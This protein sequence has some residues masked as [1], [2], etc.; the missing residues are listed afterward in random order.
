MDYESVRSHGRAIADAV[1]ASDRFRL[2]YRPHPLT[3]TVDS[4]V[5][6]AD[7]AIRSAVH[8]AAQRDPAAGHRVDT[9]TDFAHLLADV[10]LR[11]EMQAVLG[12][13]Q[14]VDGR[15]TLH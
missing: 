5:A 11:D 3:G 10:V 2:V 12:P 9:T 4:N 8:E 1:L 7:A 14:P 13:E 15:G 6:R